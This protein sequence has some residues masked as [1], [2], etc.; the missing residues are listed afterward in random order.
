MEFARA[1]ALQP[2]EW[3]ILQEVP[4]ASAHAI[5][6]GWAGAL[7]VPLR[8]YRSDQGQVVI[9]EVERRG[10]RRCACGGCV[11]GGGR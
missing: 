6:R 3:F 11:S 2:G 9:R 8:T 4:K 1:E 5:V 10:R 7:G